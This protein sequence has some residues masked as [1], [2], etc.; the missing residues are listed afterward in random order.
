[1]A[2][3]LLIPAYKLL[4]PTGSWTYLHANPETLDTTPD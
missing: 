1:M 4:Q 3:T 2:K